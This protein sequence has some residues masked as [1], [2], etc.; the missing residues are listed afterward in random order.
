LP[1][2]QEVEIPTAIKEQVHTDE[3][4][5]AEKKE[6]NKPTDSMNFDMM[7]TLLFYSS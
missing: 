1:H 7:V 3:A 4:F 5:D 6:M 2:W